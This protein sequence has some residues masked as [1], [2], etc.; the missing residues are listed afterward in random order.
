MFGAGGGEVGRLNG[1]LPD[2]ETRYL[3][4]L[5]VCCGSLLGR[6]SPSLG[7]FPG[8]M[9]SALLT[10]DTLPL[11]LFEPWGLWAPP[12]CSLEL[13]SPAAPTVP[14]SLLLELPDGDVFWALY[15]RLQV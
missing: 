9:R 7:S 12:F 8:Q 3:L 10:A 4:L 2:A 15:T 13:T 14:Y 6:F 5:G 11:V 1:F